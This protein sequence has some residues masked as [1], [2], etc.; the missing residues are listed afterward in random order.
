M[1][2]LEMAKKSIYELH[3][4]VLLSFNSTLTR[5]QINEFQVI[6]RLELGGDKCEGTALH[7]WNEVLA[8]PRRQ[9]AE[10][11]KLRE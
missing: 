5:N 7:H 4:I 2:K 9:I 3:Y 11:H 1:A 6:G 8:S 10:W